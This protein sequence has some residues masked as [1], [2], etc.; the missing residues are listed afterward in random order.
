MNEET[1]LSANQFTALNSS[2][3]DTVEDAFC[4]HNVDTGNWW[5]PTESREVNVSA[6]PVNNEL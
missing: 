6:I 1:L 3:A 4:N 5:R 2:Y